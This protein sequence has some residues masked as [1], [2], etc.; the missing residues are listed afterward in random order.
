MKSII[1]S[2]RYENN[3]SFVTAND[4][5]SKVE[6]STTFMN[7]FVIIVLVKLKLF[8]EKLNL[9]ARQYSL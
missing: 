5:I 4:K 1:L 6:F 7:I 8:K 2:I 9:L 3:L